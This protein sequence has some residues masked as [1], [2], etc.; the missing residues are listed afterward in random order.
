[1]HIICGVK[2]K[3][4]YYTYVYKDLV[5]D[6][7]VAGLVRDPIDKNR[8][9]AHLYKGSFGDVGDPMCKRG[10]NRKEWGYS[11]WRNVFTSKGICKI[12]L[13]RAEKGLDPIPF[14]YDTEEDL[15]EDSIN[16]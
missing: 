5:P 15:D 14:P 7:Y 6:G 9:V 8:H 3:M 13:R 11:I 4:D 2:N 12:C 1:M 10:W 16:V